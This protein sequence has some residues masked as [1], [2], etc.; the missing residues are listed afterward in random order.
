[1]NVVK[2]YTFS[3]TFNARDMIIVSLNIF[4][5]INMSASDHLKISLKIPRFEN[6]HYERHFDTFFLKS[7]YISQ[8]ETCLVWRLER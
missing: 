8:S 4:V 3:T 7:K 1:M 6:S 5:L 2:D